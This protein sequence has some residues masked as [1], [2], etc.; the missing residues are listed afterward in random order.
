M[1]EMQYVN[2]AFI[3]YAESVI[4][5]DAKQN[6][7]PGVLIIIFFPYPFLS[8]TL[9]SHMRWEIEREREGIELDGCIKRMEKR[10]EIQAA[11]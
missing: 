2:Y 9:A 5:L 6:L 8:I 7:F 3:N 10:K 1:T 11:N 4:T